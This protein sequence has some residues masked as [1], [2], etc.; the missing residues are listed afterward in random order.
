MSISKHRRSHHFR[1]AREALEGRRLLSG[2]IRGVDVDGDL[3]T[4]SLVGPGAISVINQNGPNGK[5]V[6]LGQP[7]LIKSITV[8]GAN[9]G[10]TQLIGVV[11]QS[12]TGDGKVFFENLTELQSIPPGNGVSPGLLSVEMPDFW[13]GATDPTNT[14]TT[15]GTIDIPDGVATLDFGGVDTTAFFGNSS[16]TPLNQNNQSDSFTVNLGLPARIG[17]SIIVDKVITANQP[18]PTTGTNPQATQ[19][20]VTF[21]VNGRLNLFQANEIDG[22]NTLDLTASNGVYQGTNTGGT[23][24]TSVDRQ[25]DQQQQLRDRR[26]RPLPGRRQRHEPDR[27]RPGDDQRPADRLLHRRRDEQ[28]LGQRPGLDPLGPVRA[29]DGHG[30]PGDQP[31]P[32]ADGQPRRGRLLDGHRPPGRHDELRR[33]RLQLDDPGRLHPGP[34]AADGPGRRPDDGPGRRRRLRLGLRR[35][36][37]AE[38]RDL[39]HGERPGGARP[40]TSTPRSRGRSTTA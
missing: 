9:P 27:Q 40:A 2:V 26:H 6:P 11:Q 37:P 7:G 34:D 10:Q 38:R 28:G 39:R 1:P 21:T 4:L 35:L 31:D 36:G 29:R 3:W 23:T 12:S 22:D 33:R 13:L 32:G 16:Q 17:T 5:P 24:V 18:A 19:D 15:Q 14:S 25:P 20:T 30:P 8:Q